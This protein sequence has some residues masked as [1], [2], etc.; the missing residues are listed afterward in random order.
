MASGDR[1]VSKV[2]RA[3]QCLI[4]FLPV[5]LMVLRLSG[6]HSFSDIF[7]N[8]NWFNIPD[9][10][11][12]FLLSL[13]STDGLVAIFSMLIMQSIILIFLGLRRLKKIEKIAEKNTNEVVKTVAFCLNDSIKSG[14]ERSLL[15]VEKLK[16]GL[17]NCL[18]LPAALTKVVS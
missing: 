9:H 6:L 18:K 1:I 12:E 14:F 4:L 5:A 13:F 16:K 15:S 7:E 11:L 3:T 10:I 17:T 8:T 2:A